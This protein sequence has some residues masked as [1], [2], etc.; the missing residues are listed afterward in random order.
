M[1]DLS[2]PIKAEAMAMQAH[3]PGIVLRSIVIPVPFPEIAP[4]ALVPTPVLPVTAL[5][6]KLNVDELKE[7]GAPGDWLPLIVEF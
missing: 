5:S 4:F 1:T 3:S 7:S 6:V 2:A